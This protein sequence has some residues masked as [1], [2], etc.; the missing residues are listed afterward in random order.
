MPSIKNTGRETNLIKELKDKLRLSGSTL[1]TI[2]QLSE[3]IVL[4]LDKN[5]IIIEASN[6]IEELF[7]IPFRDIIGKISWDSFVPDEE[8]ERIT[9]YFFDRA[10]GTANPPSTYTLRVKIP[11]K[12]SRLM[13]A[14]E[15]FIPGTEDRVIILKD[16]SDVVLEQRKTAETEE[17]YRTVVENTKDGIL[18]C[19][20]DRILFANNS[21]CRM[22]ALP[23]EDIYILSPMN[24]FHEEDRDKIESLF[25][26][27]RNRKKGTPV[28]ETLIKRSK[29]FLPAELS[30]TPMVYRDKEAVLISI[31]DLTQRKKTEKKLK[32][33]HKLMKAIVDNSPVGISVHDRNGTL[34]MA[35]ASWRDIWNK[36]IED[37][38][39][40]MV[41][42]T[43]L[44][45][46]EKDSYL[47]EHISGVE[48]VY[49][50]GGELY[51]PK[52]KIPNPP[53]GGAEFIS[54]H[55]YAL[56]DDNGE[57]DKVVNLTLDLT[58]S[59]KTKV[60][61][62]ETRNQY[63][64]LT[65]NIPVAVYRTTIGSGGKIVFYNPEMHR[66][67]LGE[68]TGNFDGISA[69]D[70]YVDPS[71]RK[72][73]LEKIA[74]NN[75][76]RGFEAELKR[77]DGSTFLA[78]ISARKVTARDGQ[79]E[80]IEGI[81]RDITAQRRLE[82]ELQRIE[83]L[84][85]IGTLAGGIAHDFNNLLMAIQGNISL[86]R[87]EEDLSKLFM[88]LEEAEASI[89]EATIL[90]RQLLTF[91]RGG[92]PLKNSV[93]VASFIREAVIFALRG[94][95]VEAVFDFEA[96]LKKIEA[97]M[98]QIAQVINNITL[99]SVQ[100][101][102]SGGRITVSCSN[103]ELEE[104]SDTH[105]KEGEYVKISI[106]DTGKGIPPDD[107]KKIFNPYFST[108]P[109]GSGLGLPTS[110]SIVSRH[111]GAIRVYSEEEMGTEFVIYLPAIGREGKKTVSE[112]APEKETPSTPSHVLIMDDDPRVR[113]VLSGMLDVLGH[114]VTES[115]DGTEAVE[116]YRERFTSGD[117]FNA[118][119]MDLTVP[120]GMG[121]EDAIEK[122]MEIDPDVKAIVSSGYANNTVLSNYPD[123][124]FS[125]RLVKPFRISTLKKE[126]NK[127]LTMS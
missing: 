53:P 81:I 68:E 125:G 7:E 10:S 97:D 74:E 28:F 65:G 113:E 116:L 17:R 93:E 79:E 66:M 12:E 123:Y 13:R 40:K 59:L 110:Y 34:L 5:G 24:F 87:N 23:R 76:I 35:N 127:V 57:V 36:S 77:L 49:R 32:E 112:D 29:E 11:G 67:F 71:G 43:E 122:L 69:K 15:G 80:Y 95:D 51:I 100:S 55:F 21:F 106:K 27:S 82:E 120:G 103:V 88:R 18:I 16:L 20:A 109:D 114:D 94:S 42:R 56:K 25:L 26:K 31:R 3:N 83:H 41:P 119:I 105:L 72:D 124:G 78:S 86:A 45:M 92:V 111:S 58:E 98:E 117:P 1:R 52:L 6:Q 14:N 54:H 102:I 91:A 85:S 84:E 46:D 8:I 108:K 44:L 63:K 104:G 2:L 70:L 107:L 126:L 22:T 4:V 99:N 64:E 121:G 50:K 115:S 9:G 47:G 89:E 118:V 101:M 75:V 38:K 90:T 37:M 73:F 61:L 19:T 30:S 33:S 39:E 96:G 60:E 48:A 62:M